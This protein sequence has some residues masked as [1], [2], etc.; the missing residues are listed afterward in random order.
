M[1]IHP[2]ARLAENASLIGEVTV[3]KGASVWYGAV[4]RGDCGAIT[5]GENSAVEDN[6]V[7]H[8][9][10]TIGKNCIIGHGA[11]LHGCTL[12]DGVLIGMG[13]TVMDG[14]V[15]GAGSL[16]AAGALVTKNTVVPPGALVMGLPGKVAG[17]LTAEQRNY[18]RHSPEKYRELAESQLRTWEALTE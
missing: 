16:V 11:I 6:C 14:A 18:L 8:G 2:G 4:L 12:A 10:V 5:L 15:L 9:E 13:A 17:P 7:L 1:K 3:E